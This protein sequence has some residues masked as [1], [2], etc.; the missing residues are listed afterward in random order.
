MADLLVTFCLGN[1]TQH[2]CMKNNKQGNVEWPEG[3]YCIY[4]KGL[5]PP[6]MM[7]SKVFWDDEDDNNTNYGNNHYFLLKCFYL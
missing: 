4:K 7:A 1:I 3:R 6:K 5:C 2:F